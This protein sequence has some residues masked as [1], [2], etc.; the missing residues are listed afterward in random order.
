MNWWGRLLGRGKM[1]EQLDKEMRFHLEQHA[2][3]LIA[4]GVGA[5]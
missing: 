5:A 2:N 3:E 4:S 1:E